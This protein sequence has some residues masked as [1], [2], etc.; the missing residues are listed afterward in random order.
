M[1]AGVARRAFLTGGLSLGPVVLAS[2]LNERPAAARPRARR[3]ISLFMV[4][5][6]SQIDLFDDKPAL[7]KFD[8]QPLPA[9]LAA[10]AKF[11]FVTGAPRL[12]GSPFRFARHGQSGAVLSEL[13]PHTARIADRL[14]FVRS[15]RTTQ[16]NHAPAQLYANTGH[17]QTGR[18][19]LGAW[20]S[21]GLGT[22][23]RELP[24]HVVLLSGE[25]QPDAGR[26]V[27][28]Q[29]FLP[30]CHAGVELRAAGDPVLFLGDPG[31]ISRASARDR[32]DAVQALDRANPLA[33]APEIAARLEAYEL[34][35]RMQTSVP[36]LVDL[37]REPASVHALYGTTPGRPSF[38]NN[39]L[40]ARRLV[41]RGCRFVQLFHRGWDTHGV[42]RTD[43]LLHRLPALCAE[44]DRAAA[45]LVV[46]LDRRGLLDDTLVI[47]GGEFG[48]TPV[49][50][51]RKGSQFLGRDHHGRAF[52]V[53]MAGGGVRSGLTLGAT[54]E[55]GY[56]VVD[57]PVGVH[58]LQ[59]TIL[60]RVGI[61]HTQ[62]TYTVQGRAF[63]LTDVE[64]R[65]VSALCA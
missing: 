21:Y 51:G 50:E 11:P 10:S 28:G 9:Q 64:G 47:W 27:W 26:S 40:M 24:T 43:D 6:P 25:R 56:D 45:A 48:R 20:L 2:L 29:G 52:T 54:D 59:A 60:E 15:L 19:S 36:G 33:G 17:E 5:G 16:V 41:E 62:L 39:C 55:L 46:D 4:G 13:L 18:P 65:V 44:T 31:G 34:A 42:T 38:A 32:V 61:D 49:N 3:V 35:F 8:G 37:A 23:N 58:D 30:A 63:R 7:R 14:T 12:L 1:T 22:L 57:H 53:W